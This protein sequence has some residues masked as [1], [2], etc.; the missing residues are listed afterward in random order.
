MMIWLTTFA[1]LKPHV[2]LAQAQADA[3]RLFPAIEK[4]T[5]PPAIM[6]MPQTAKVTLN[7]ESARTGWSTLRLQF[8]RPLLLL[9]ALVGVVLLL[10]CAN[11]SG[12]FLARA[13]ARRQE[14]AIRASL[15]A[16]RGRLMRQ[17]FVESLM[18]AIPGALA[19]IGLSWLAGPWMLHSLG[20]SIAEAALSVHPDF[21]VLAI[22][23]ACACL[24]ALLFGM[25]PAWMAS[26]TRIEGALR[27]SNPNTAAG[28]ALARRILIPLQ[29]ALSLSLVVVAALL[30]ATVVHLRTDD[31][32]FRTQN[33]IFY[34]ADFGRLPQKGADLVTLYRRI[35][36]RL[37]EQPGVDAASAVEILPYYGWTDRAA[38]TA[39]DPQHSRT[40]DADSNEIA[41]HYFATVGTPLLAGRDFRNDDADL[42]S[43]IVNKSAAAQYFPQGS[44]LG[45]LLHAVN[46]NV[47][48]GTTTVIDCQVVG[49]VGDTKYDTVRE[50]PPPI[51][52]QPISGDS[53]RLN[54][55]FFAIHARSLAEASTAYHTVIH[56]EAP[57]S[58]ETDPA[59]FDKLFSD[60]M[61][62]EELL[63]SLSG[64][65]AL[66]ALLLSSIG[67]YGLVA[68]NVS[69]RT[70]E[71]GLRIA[72]GATRAKVF[73]MILRQ[74]TVLLAIGL[75][76]GSGAAFFAARSVSSF[77][78]ETH[79]ESPGIFLA[80]AAV[81]VGIGLLAA[82]LPAR[83]A[84]TIDPMQALRT[85]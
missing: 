77:L 50:S 66:L 10:C 29:L 79:A 46:H 57:L 39:G 47:E 38:F 64:F 23:A 85:E 12:L 83:R 61:A 65:F 55:L 69:Q 13:S 5:L 52:Y 21:A 71:L 26:R 44:A 16:G 76:L 9:Q 8:T 42:H 43:C 82:L 48:T 36:Q 31:T 59:I 67:I 32:G 41:A 17:L 72:L 6:R 84:V 28:S 24:C 62:R 11:L 74:T 15:G 58:P 20:N 75:A 4:A 78:Y 33:V 63:S 30:G 7:V 35:L 51:V 40:V 1:R 56:E 19:G 27:A 3:G 70:R 37:E 49:I 68:W 34:I 80:A 25:A 73:F 18:L 14:F 53:D 60:S 45:K 54:G 2:T 22:T 81:L